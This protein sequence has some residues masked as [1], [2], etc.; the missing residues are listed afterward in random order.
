MTTVN[1]KIPDEAAKFKKE[2]FPDTKWPDVI[3]RGLQGLKADKLTA[4]TK[5]AEAKVQSSKAKS[6]VVLPKNDFKP[7]KSMPGDSAYETES[8]RRKHLS[9]EPIALPIKM[10]THDYDLYNPTKRM[11]V[12]VPFYSIAEGQI[13]RIRDNGRV[14]KVGGHKYLSYFG[15]PFRNEERDLCMQVIGRQMRF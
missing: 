2:N 4:E 11:W 5:A 6:D 9:N 12:T 8:D 1:C 13:F 3:K 7:P 14:I 15:A 10:E